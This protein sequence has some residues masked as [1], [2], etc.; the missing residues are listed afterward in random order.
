MSQDEA[1]VLVQGLPSNLR[2][3]TMKELGI[4]EQDS[5]PSYKKTVESILL[6][7]EAARKVEEDSM[8]DQQD[9][10]TKTYNANKK[11]LTSLH[12]KAKRGGQVHV[13]HT[14]EKGKKQSGRYNGM[15]RM[16]AHTYAKIEPHDGKKG[17]T[18]LLPIHQAQN[19]RHVK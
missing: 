12:R 1:K 2:K 9:Q 8:S 7:R 13:D 3:S 11:S 19:I 14:D 18:T 4:K 15:M 16:G 6:K 5:K 17:G 10:A